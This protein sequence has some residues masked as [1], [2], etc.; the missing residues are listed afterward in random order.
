MLLS[1]G[2]IQIEACPIAEAHFRASFGWADIEWRGPVR[3]RNQHIAVRLSQQQL[4]WTVCRIVLLSLLGVFN[5][6]YVNI[7]VTILLLYT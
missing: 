4:Q 1:V 5:S 7:Q 6:R 3:V 2:E